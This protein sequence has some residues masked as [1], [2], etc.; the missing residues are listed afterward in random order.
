M[1]PYIPNTTKDVEKMLADIGLS[2]TDRLFDDIP[3]DLKLN[4]SLNIGEPLTEFDIARYMNN[5]SSKNRSINE[6]TCFLGAGAYDHYIPSLVDHVISRSEF[7]TSYTPY[8]P[9]ISQGTLQTIFEFQSLISNLTGMDVANAS[10]Y[11]GATAIAEAIIM[12]TLETRKN[13]VVIS[14][15]VNPEYRKVVKTYAKALNVRLIEVPEKGGITDIDSLKEVVT[16]DTA[17][18]IVQNPN[19]FGIIEDIRD[20][21]KITHSAKKAKLIMSV[22]PISLGILKS[23][24]ELGADI[25]VG[26]GQP[27]GNKLSFGGPYLGFMAT[28]TKLMR[29][30]PG[31]IVGQTEDLDGK[32]AFVLT[33]QAREQHIRRDKASSNICSNQALNALAATVYLTS[34][35]KKGLREVALQSARKANYAFEKLTKTGKYKPVF[36]KPFFREF[37]LSSDINSKDIN[38]HLM[39]N[40]ILG[41]YDIEEDYPQYKGSIMYC[42]TEKRTKT[43]INQ[44]VEVLEGVE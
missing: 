3:D 10:V 6:L 26:E 27:L 5:I 41:G 21:E 34:L 9:E 28:T 30:L 38:K 17:A 36:N 40:G 1:F 15:T 20:I 32:R 22:D 19:F 29:R 35:G 23:P 37:V 7:Y 33:L 16:D 12:A 42:V 31:R 25:V 43:E 2:S 39:N 4:R 13:E 11:D 44:L 18:V 14:A 24:G 8:Q